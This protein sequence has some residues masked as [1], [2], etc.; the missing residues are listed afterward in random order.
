MPADPDYIADL[1][2][3]ILTN[4]VQALSDAAQNIPSRRYIAPGFTPIDDLGEDCDGALTVRFQGFF[5]G[6]PG[7]ET[8]DL[9]IG[10]YARTAVF[11]LRLVRCLTLGPQNEPSSATQAA[12]ATQA[13][14]DAW[15]LF[16]GLLELNASGS[17]LS[18]CQSWR[19]SDATAVGPDET[20][21]GI[22]LLLQVQV[23]G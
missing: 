5:S 1:A 2:E 4:A 22:E 21:A 11:A 23:T 8:S 15:V 19:I 10:G 6:L 13:M 20:V 9:E 7:R 16:Q 3:E 17:F 18:T 12:D 14:T